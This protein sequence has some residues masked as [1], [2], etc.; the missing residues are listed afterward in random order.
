MMKRIKRIIL[1]SIFLV[2]Q[3]V[4]LFSRE[5]VVFKFDIVQDIMPSAWQVTKRAIAQAESINA[6][7]ILIRI[8]T[9]GGLV[10]TADSIRTRIL[11]CR[12]PVLA[13]IDNNAASA[14]ALIAIAADSIYMRKGASI[15]AATVV[16]QEGKAVPDKYQSYMRAIMRSTA[17]AHGKKPVVKGNDT[18]W[19][20]HRDPDI[21]QAM[22]DPRI[23]IKGVNDSGK[24]LTLTTAEAIAVGFCEGEAENVEEVLQKAGITNYRIQEY[25]ATLLDKLI[26]FFTHPIVQG[27]LI[28]IIVAGIYF[29][30]QTPGIGFPL[31]AAITAAVLYF[32]PLYLE[33]L[34]QHWEIIL[35]IVGLILLAVEIFLIPG[36]GVTGILGITLVIIGLTM[37]MVEKLPDEPIR[38]N[39]LAPVLKA[40]VTVVLSITLSFILSLYLSSK[41]IGHRQ[42]RLAL[43]A[44]QKRN[45]GFV[46]VEADMLSSL[47]GKT[48]K[49]VT[50]LRPAGKIEV[51]GEI[52]D[53]ISDS[54]FIEPDANVKV[55]KTLAGQLYV[56][57]L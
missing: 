22:V 11:N 7:Y 6:D 19:V 29:E 41:I 49:A 25:R 37:A 20:W 9:Y 35:F 42:F 57:K 46:G 50:V 28:M 10:N 34:A 17:Q 13:F 16:D 12:I 15:G 21:A 51:E 31:I 27:I 44:E 14:G 4:T 56:I 45:E 5:T 8:N 23:A 39:F 1:A 54:G 33:G 53:A 24:V 55:I 36:F 40:F 38:M 26:G 48:G 18:I 47:I 2:S 52:Y 32:S 30:L 3:S 43:Q